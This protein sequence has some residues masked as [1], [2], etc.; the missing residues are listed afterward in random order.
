MLSFDILISAYV[1]LGPM[2]L[3]HLGPE[4]PKTNITMSI[5]DAEQLFLVIRL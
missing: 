2:H 3:P 1:N 4:L 5:L